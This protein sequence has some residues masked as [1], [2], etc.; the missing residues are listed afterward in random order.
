MVNPIRILAAAGGHLGKRATSTWTK[1]ISTS[2]DLVSQATSVTVFGYYSTTL[3]VSGGTTAVSTISETT[4]TTFSWATS[5]LTSTT[6]LDPACSTAYTAYYND[7][8][9]VTDVVNVVPTFIVG[10]GTACLPTGWE[11]VAYYS[12]GICPSGYELVFQTPV[13]TSSLE[14]AGLCCY[15]SYTRDEA[16]SCASFFN[17]GRSTSGGSVPTSTAPITRWT[18]TAQYTS[19]EETSS[20]Y[21][22]PVVSGLSITTAPTTSYSSL[23]TSTMLTIISGAL[24]AQIIAPEVYIRWKSTDQI[25]M[26]WLTQQTISGNGNP[27]NSTAPSSP[28]THTGLSAGAIAGIAIGA[29]V[30]LGLL[31]GGLV[32]LLKK[33]KTRALSTRS[34]NNGKYSLQNPLTTKVWL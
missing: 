4:S 30:A 28:P 20:V 1:V 11:T 5:P 24:A 16:G 15:K 33:R 21:N 9:Y 32:F 8:F 14:T 3:V 31:I 25:V 27:H 6:P 19:V 17:S 34:E 22:T 23:A 26:D 7:L 29:V 12:P 10:F 18:V 13:A 2:Y